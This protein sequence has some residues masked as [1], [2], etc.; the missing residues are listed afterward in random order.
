MIDAAHLTSWL[1]GLL[2]ASAAACLQLQGL[3]LQGASAAVCL[4]KRGWV[5]PAQAQQG[6][7]LEVG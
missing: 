4:H 6:W 7:P 2:L 5:S 3:Q 1:S